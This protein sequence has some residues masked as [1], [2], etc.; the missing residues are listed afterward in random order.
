MSKCDGYCST[1][2]FHIDHRDFWNIIWDIA[3]ADHYDQELNDF[4]EVQCLKLWDLLR[5]KKMI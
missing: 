1:C 4:L 2:E 5:D 3:E